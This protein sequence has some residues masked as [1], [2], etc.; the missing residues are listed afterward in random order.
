MD[1]ATSPKPV[2]RISIIGTAGCGK[3]TLAKQLSARL[4]IPHVELDACHWGPNWTPVANAIFLSQV[5]AALEQENWVMDGNYIRVRFNIWEQ[6]THIVWLDYPRWRIMQ[7]V[8]TRSL[9]RI[10]TREKL[11]AG[12]RETVQKSFFSQ[13]SII[14]FAWKSYERQKRDYEE[15]FSFSLFRDTEVVR[16]K[17]PRETRQWVENLGSERGGDEGMG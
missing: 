13:D 2:W 17:S 10:L 1:E 4:G 15:L 3:T 16:L 7:Q 5:D 6:A 9:R 12:N 11:W 8:T 14:R